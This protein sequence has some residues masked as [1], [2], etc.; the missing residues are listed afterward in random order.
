M[1]YRVKAVFSKKYTN[2]LVKGHVIKPEDLKNGKLHMIRTDC[3]A[4][5]LMDSMS[6]LLRG[7]SCGGLVSVK[8]EGYE[9]RR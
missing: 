6:L 8:I 1:N 2:A 9:N 3:D 4:T 7:L 5:E